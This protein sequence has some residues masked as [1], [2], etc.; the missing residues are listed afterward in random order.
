MPLIGDAGNTFAHVSGSSGVF[1]GPR[2]GLC[3]I[4]KSKLQKTPKTQK[5]AKNA[6]NNERSI[7][8][9][10]AGGKFPLELKPLYLADDNFATFK[11]CLL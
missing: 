11:P 2:F 10:P 1:Q 9:Y 7:F 3:K 6:K 8:T 4:P 5:K